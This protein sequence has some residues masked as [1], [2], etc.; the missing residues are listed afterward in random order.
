MLLS[1]GREKEIFGGESL[2]T[3]NRME[4]MAV[5]E[6]L[7]ALKQ[8]CEVVLHLDSEYVRKGITDQGLQFI[9][10][11]RGCWWLGVHG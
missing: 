8:P 6:A 10:T 1:A 4:L 9:L 11:Q 5:I 3:N 2:T 7:R